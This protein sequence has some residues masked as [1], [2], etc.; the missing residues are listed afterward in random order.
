LID[1]GLRI[2][3]FAAVAVALSG[4][5]GSKLARRLTEPILA[6]S[7]QAKAM[8]TGD[9]STRVYIPPTTEELADLSSD[10]NSLAGEF[11]AMLDKSAAERNE[12][13]AVLA[14]LSDAVIVV[15]RQGR[16][17]LFNAAAERTFLAREETVHGRPLLEAAR[18]HELWE[19]FEEALQGQ[20]AKREVRIYTPH[21]RAFE[22]RIAPV[23]RASGEIS[24]AVGVLD[25][26]TEL[27]SLERMRADFVANVSHELKTPVTSIK[28]F[29][30]TLLDGALDDAG[31][32]RHF[33]EIIDRESARLGRLVEDLLELS[34]IESHRVELRREPVSLTGLA[35]ETVAF[36]LP[37][38]EQRGV[39]LE[40]QVSEELPLV[41][42]DRELL[43]QVLR[44]LVDNAV[45]YTPPGG[46]VWVH[47]KDDG[48]SISLSVS[49]TG[50]GIAPEHLP[51]LFER[52]YR[53][54][55]AR[56]REVGGTGL[57]LSIVKHV[58]ERHRG[59]VT[60]DS[61]LGQGSTF[62]VTIP[63]RP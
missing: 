39:N 54:D 43:D 22:A 13:Q 63:K 47:G 2:L 51:R 59:R 7:R 41:E 17:L 21:E 6:M 26:I 24:G 3:A 60:V 36:Y 38:A 23:R 11:K 33:V 31:T 32:A 9:F 4:F 55:K 62:T 35:A 16:V 50:P 25:D 28:G 40:T 1:L 34:R 14:S 20:A 49:D 27:R 53:V 52:F 58:V 29:A 15:D 57:G 48:E 8:A 56:S 10:L 18:Y 30:E 42:A 37:V 45:K 5:A 46:R 44:N 19:A 61:V 12:I